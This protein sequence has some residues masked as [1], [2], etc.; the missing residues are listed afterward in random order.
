[1]LLTDSL[2]GIRIFFLASL[3]G[4]VSGLSSQKENAVTACFFL[5]LILS[6]SGLRREGFVTIGVRIME[7][8]FNEVSRAL[9]GKRFIWGG[10]NSLL[11]AC[12]GR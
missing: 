8:G 9:D 5:V 10:V 1:M 6:R 11:A 7:K 12:R 3:P 2:V 4:F